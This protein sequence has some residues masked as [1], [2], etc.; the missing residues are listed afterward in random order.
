MWSDVRT[1]AVVAMF[2]GLS[3]LALVARTVKVGAR[4][5]A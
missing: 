4:V 3:V 5:E 1:D 2:V